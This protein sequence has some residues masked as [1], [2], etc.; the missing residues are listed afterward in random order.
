MELKEVVLFG[1]TY[2][3]TWIQLIYFRLALI[4][5]GKFVCS[6]KTEVIMK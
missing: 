4:M 1:L 3:S 2:G 5:Q 6:K